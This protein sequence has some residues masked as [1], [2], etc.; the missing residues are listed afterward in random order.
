MTAE[1][2]KQLQDK[3]AEAQRLFKQIRNLACTSWSDEL[4]MNIILLLDH[5]K[6]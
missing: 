2:I 5:H 4:A 3:L 6:C 1:E